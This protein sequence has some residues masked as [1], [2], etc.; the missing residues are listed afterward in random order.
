MGV[1]VN[2]INIFGVGSPCGFSSK[3]PEQGGPSKY[4]DAVVSE[5]HTV[6]GCGG[7]PAPTHQYHVHSGIGMTTNYKREM[8]QLPQ[9][10]AGEHSKLL[11]WLFD[12]FGIYGR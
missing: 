12:G 5:G 3:C 6:D 1:L 11:G 2:G 10:V 4:V 7:H 8:C 9:D